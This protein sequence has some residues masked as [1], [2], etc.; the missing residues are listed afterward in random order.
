MNGLHNFIFSSLVLKETFSLSETEEELK[1]IWNQMAYEKYRTVVPMKPGA[2]EF[3]CW[4]KAHGYATAVCTS[5]SRELIDMI[6]ENKGIKQWIDFV[7][8]ACEVNAGKPAPDIYLRAAQELGVEPSECVV[9]ED[10]PAIGCKAAYVVE[11]STG[12]ILYEK[13]VYKKLVHLYAGCLG[14]YLCCNLYIADINKP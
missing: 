6:V 2:A 3:L 1:I 5:N 12:K 13:N 9:F 8:T 10:I 7:V 11:P 14:G 4:L